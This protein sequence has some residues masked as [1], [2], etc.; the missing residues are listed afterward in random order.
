MRLAAFG[1][2]LLRFN[3]GLGEFEGLLQEVDRVFDAGHCLLTEAFDLLGEGQ[4]DGVGVVV[5]ASLDACFDRVEHVLNGD[6][7]N[8]VDVDSG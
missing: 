6:R 1:F 2:E 4:I 8:L 5:Q 7:F 3:H